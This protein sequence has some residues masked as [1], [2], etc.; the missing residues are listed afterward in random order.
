MK[1]VRLSEESYNKLK[2]RLINEI[3]Y[4]TVDRAYDRSDELFYEIM[5]RFDDFYN[6]LEEALITAKY[7]KENPY[8]NKLK[9]L[10]DPIKD[11]LDRK[12]KQQ[13]NFFDATTRKV[14]VG[15]FFNSD[16][17]NDKSIDDMDLRY[18]QDNYPK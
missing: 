12:K 14:D 5:S 7:N 11:I 17:A 8:L 18:L 1:K 6:A 2:E 9:E 15:K 4:G 16:D 13:D 10:A 3:S